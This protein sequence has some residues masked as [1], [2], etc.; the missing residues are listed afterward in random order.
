MALGARG[1]Q[2]ALDLLVR[3]LDDGRRAMR[4]R[5]LQAFRFGMPRPLALARLRS[6]VDSLSHTD[7]KQAVADAITQ[8]G[9]AREGE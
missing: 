9:T 2:R 6:A 8:L 7:T 5:A 4:D 3:R 1:S